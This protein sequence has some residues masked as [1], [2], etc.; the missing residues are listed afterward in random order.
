MPFQQRSQTRASDQCSSLL[1]NEHADARAGRCKR[2]PRWGSAGNPIGP[3][4][5]G[6]PTSRVTIDFP[7]LIHT[8]AWR[9]GLIF[10]RRFL[11]DHTYTLLQTYIYVNAQECLLHSRKDSLWS[12]ERFLIDPS[13]TFL[14]LPAKIS[15]SSA[16]SRSSQQVPPCQNVDIQICRYTCNARWPITIS[17]CL[18]M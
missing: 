2:L 16:F 4:W 11:L 12:N 6:T 14:I 13:S 5:G 1:R 18:M 10:W 3:F 15:L 8:T 7:M 9:P 17:F